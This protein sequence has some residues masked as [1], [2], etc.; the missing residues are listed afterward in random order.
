MN[1]LL[2][3]D[4]GI[5]FEG[6]RIL[7][8]VFSKQFDVFVV[9]PEG[10][11]SSQSHHLTIKGRIRYEE[12]KMPFAKKAYA[13]WG[14]PADCVH[15]GLHALLD[16]KIDLVVSGINKGANISTDIIYSG[17]ISAAREAFIY[18]VP[19]MAPSLDRNG[20]DRYDVAAKI[21]LQIALAYLEEKDR[22]DYF[23]NVNVPDRKMEEIRGFRICDRAGRMDY[24]DSY[25]LKK[26]DDGDYIV[27][28]QSDV[29]FLGDPE[30]LGID[31][32]ALRKG[33]VSVSPM[34]NDQFSHGHVKVLGEMIEKME[35]TL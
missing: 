19:A 16:E 6:I 1:V 13:L 18:H 29:R 2:T 9:A 34:G 24:G 8:E 14:T 17:T 25:S 21:G 3:N 31:A 20:N 4:D 5:D 10:E 33:Y 30:D 11:R 23:L 12:R 35:K 27:I 15:M 22:E 28:G 26:E 32:S 7:A